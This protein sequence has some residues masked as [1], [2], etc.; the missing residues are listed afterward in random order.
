MTDVI[1]RET[2]TNSAQPGISDARLKELVE[3]ARAEG[4]QLTGDGGLLSKL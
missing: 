4:L 2:E 3:Q 1:D